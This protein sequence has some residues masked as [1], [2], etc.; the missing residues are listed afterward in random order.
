M[1]LSW[2]GWGLQHLPVKLSPDAR[3]RLRSR[4][5][6]R[7]LGCDPDSDTA[8]RGGQTT[9]TSDAKAS[10]GLMDL[11][12]D[13]GQ[14]PRDPCNLN[15]VGGSLIPAFSSGGDRDAAVAAHTH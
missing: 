14:S 5:W 7:G 15:G 11:M 10:G 2:L 6:G 9:Q 1:N 12:T 8:L 13:A 3:I 4:G